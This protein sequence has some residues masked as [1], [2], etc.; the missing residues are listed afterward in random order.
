[1]EGDDGYCTYAM[2]PI[3]SKTEFTDTFKTA[4]GVSTVCSRGIVT[5]VESQR[6]TL[7]HIYDEIQMYGIIVQ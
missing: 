6:L 3:S 1:M 5:Y 4:V 7:V 2:G